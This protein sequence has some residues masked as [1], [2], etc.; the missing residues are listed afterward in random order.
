MLH[1]REAGG[2]R[3][4]LRD[5]ATWLGFIIIAIFDLL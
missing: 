1:Q 4:P 3:A 5:A 2:A